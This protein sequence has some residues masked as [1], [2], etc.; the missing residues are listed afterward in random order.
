MAWWRAWWDNWQREHE[1]VVK[2]I[3]KKNTLR[4]YNR[5]YASD[6]LLAQYLVPE[7]IAFYKEVVARCLPLAPRRIID[8]GCG[9]GSL[10]RILIE[11][12]PVAPE[13]V[14][15]VDRSRA[16]IRRARRLAPQI[17]WV[18]GDLRR[19]PSQDRFDLVLCTEV[20]EHVKRPNEA[21]KTFTRL[22]APSGRVV[23]TVPDGERD[24]WE[25]HANFWSEEEFKALLA[26]HGLVAIERIQ[27]G[28]V[29][30]AWLA[31]NG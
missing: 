5:I 3:A 31:P 28:D 7:R 10:L 2:N 17:R 11:S 14:V 29:L 15:G 13:A 21:L 1:P 19:L 12:L 8:V 26:P 20:L 4:A 9:P 27:E 25:G 22:C 23:L 18:V 30:L 16:G 24:S 6:E